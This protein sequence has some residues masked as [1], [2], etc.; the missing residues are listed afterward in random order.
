[1]K[2]LQDPDAGMSIGLFGL[3]LQSPVHL[4]HTMMPNSREMK[5]M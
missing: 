2:T 1:M 5:E 4:A 3:F